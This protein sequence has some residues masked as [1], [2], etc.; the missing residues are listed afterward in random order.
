[1]GRR[2]GFS[3]ESEPIGFYVYMELA[4]E[5]M[6]TDKPQGIQS[7][8]WRTW[9]ANGVILVQRSA[10]LWQRK[11]HYFSLSLN[12]GKN[13]PLAQL[14]GRAEGIP[15]IQWENQPFVFFRP[16]VNG[17]RPTHIRTMFDQIAEYL[18]GQS[19]WYINLTLADKW[20]PRYVYTGRKGGRHLNPKLA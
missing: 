9:R 5:I 18:M 3:V 14:E 19:S 8:N 20:T 6:N 15:D 2:L 17:M 13:I 4:H 11:S 10:S 12:A 7:T 1:M 16:S